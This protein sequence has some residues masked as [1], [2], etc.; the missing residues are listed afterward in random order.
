MKLNQAEL[1][2]T[3]GIAVEADHGGEISLISCIARRWTRS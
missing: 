1:A 2:A 3:A